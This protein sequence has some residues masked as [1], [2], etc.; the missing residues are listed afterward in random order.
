MTQ[1]IVPSLHMNMYFVLSRTAGKKHKNNP[2][3]SVSFLIHIFYQH[4]LWLIDE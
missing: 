2:T 1:L 4:Y 3:V